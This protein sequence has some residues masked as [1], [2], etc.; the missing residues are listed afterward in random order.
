MSPRVLHLSTTDLKGGAARGSYWLHRALVERSVDSTMLVERKYANDD[1]VLGGASGG[2]LLRR[3]RACAE[4]MSLAAYHK[5]DDSYW[6]V[7]WVPSPI[8]RAVDKLAP[9]IVHIHWSGGGFLPIEAVARLGRPVV[10][11]L[12]DMWPFTGGC[13]YTAGCEGY[14]H[15]CGNCPQLRSDRENDISRWIFDRKRRHWRGVPLHLVPISSWLADAARASPLF[16]HVPVDIIPNGIDT[17]KF[18]SIDRN[19][20][21]RAWNLPTDRHLVLF[22]AINATQDPRKGFAHLRMAI[23]RLAADGF[24]KRGMLVIF[25]ADKERDVDF[26]GVPVRYLGHV[27]DDRRLAKLYGAADVMVVP[28]L[29]EAFGKTLIEAMACA[30]PVV[31]FDHGGPSDIVVHKVTGYLAQPFCHG[32]LAAGI[33]WCLSSGDRC[34]RLGRAARARAEID[35]D[36]HGIA[37]RYEELYRRIAD[38]GAMARS[39]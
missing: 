25:G 34:V 23:R 37:R 19:T 39:A 36:I 12:R 5:T 32:D 1:T 6:S 21:R 30:T 38:N 27:D 13:H 28:S 29:Q 16:H 14:R 7:N 18:S 4:E 35:Y 8:C 9:D 2:P 11:T 3:A 20:A 33:A 31:A 22:G 10:W 17:A 24:A 26:G 15:A